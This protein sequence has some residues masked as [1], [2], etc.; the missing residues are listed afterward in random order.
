MNLDVYFT[1]AELPAS[2]P[3]DANI[4][5]IDV[6]RATST[7]TE[8]LANGARAV[9]PVR[10]AEEASVLAARIGRDQTLVCGER[11]GVKLDGFDLGNSPLEY[12]AERVAGKVLALT[13]TNGTHA[14]LAVAGGRH[15]IV[16]SFLNLSA[17][18]DALAS[19]G[20]PAV[21][22]CAGREGRFALED[23]ACAGA[24]ALSLTERIEGVVLNDAAVAAV[25]LARPVRAAPLSMLRASAGGKALTEIGFE[26]DLD[27]CAAVD[28]HALVPE[29]RDQRVT[30]TPAGK[31]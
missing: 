6:L 25:A 9:C 3:G 1:P 30:L 15:V 11:K 4:V 10:T 12:T 19:S 2:G 8:A 29:L 28:R 23:G 20:G 16:A 22:V 31:A 14:L 26:E 24:I 27:F 13:T 18:V 7:M 17:V 5:V 21:I